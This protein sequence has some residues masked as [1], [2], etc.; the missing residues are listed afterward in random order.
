MAR[1]S[2]HAPPHGNG[3]PREK[4]HANPRRQA[5]VVEKLRNR[6]G[7]RDP[8]V[9]TKRLLQETLFQIC[10]PIGVIA[11]DNRKGISFSGTFLRRHADDTRFEREKTFDRPTARYCCACGDG[12]H[13]AHRLRRR[14]DAPSAGP[15]SAP[16]RAAALWAAAGSV[17][18][19]RA[20]I[21]SGTA[22]RTAPLV[23]A[24]PSF[25]IFRITLRIFSEGV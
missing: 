1:S 18:S 8:Q 20:R 23:A 22:S 9:F 13:L 10:G 17:A 25:R 4:H 6:R 16:S 21:P 24:K 5:P 14:A 15:R 19:S 11:L 7:E 2:R 12:E 3:R